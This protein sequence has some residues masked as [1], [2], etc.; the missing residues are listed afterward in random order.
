MTKL[1]TRARR[2]PR[3]VVTDRLDDLIIV[4]QAVELLELG[5]EA[6]AE[7]GHQGEEVG[8]VV[9]IPEHGSGVP[10][11]RSKRFLSM[12]SAYKKP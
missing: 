2:P 3:H 12:P 11:V 4:E 5:L 6:E 7:S 1:R 9:S 10:S 8:P